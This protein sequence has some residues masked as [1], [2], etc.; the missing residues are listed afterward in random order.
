[1]AGPLM[2]VKKNARY[3]VDTV[4]TVPCIA[5]LP[6][7]SGHMRH[8]SHQSRGRDC[9]SCRHRNRTRLLALAVCIVFLLPN[10]P[11]AADCKAM[12]KKLAKMRNEYHEYVMGQ[13][14][15]EGSLT[16]EDLAARLDEIVKFKS[17][18]RKADC[19]VPPRSKWLK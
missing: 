7:L 10:V 14:R 11:C 13:D 9:I 1:M 6:V 17:E 15:D 12:A 16:F 2:M 18:M 5:G 8:V 3:V 4:G 19:N